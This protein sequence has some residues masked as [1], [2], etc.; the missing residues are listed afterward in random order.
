VKMSFL[1]VYLDSVYDLFCE[2]GSAQSTQSLKVREGDDG[3]YAHGEEEGR[4]RPYFVSTAVLL[5]GGTTR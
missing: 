1:Q 4:P 5:R 2:A 3:F